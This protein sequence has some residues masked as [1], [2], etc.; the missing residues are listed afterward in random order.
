M[1]KLQL[2][3]LLPLLFAHVAL[4][5]NAIPPDPAA[6]AAA[7]RQLADS[8]KPVQGE[9]LLKG[10]AAKAV[11]PASLQYL[12]AKDTEVV[13]TKIWGNP[14]GSG[15]LGMV[16]PTGFDPLSDD[17]W[18][19]IMTLE[20][21]GYVKDDDAARIDYTKLLAEMKEG[22]VEANKARQKEGY[23]PIELVGWASPPRY[24]AAEK[25]LY[26]A[27]ELKFGNSPDHTLNYNLRLLGRRG[28]L[29]LNAVA[30]MSQLKDVEAATPAI[31]AAV[32]FQEGHRYADFNQSTDKTATYGVAAL[33]AG[34]V[35][36]KTG[37][38]KGLWIGILAFKKFAIIGI[39]ALVALIRKIWSSVRGRPTSAFTNTAGDGAP[40]VA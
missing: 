9:I 7:M 17:S 11:L 25:K 3:L 10:G 34:G 36:A 39:I 30:N 6:R 8:L 32:N 20:E 40:P 12:N 35:A 5:A 33:V 2:L 27:K 1:K 29:V 24:D 37:L 31:L 38:L 14:S 23:E 26:W 16:V 18:A 28:V 13:L 22:M 19:V 15:T 4:G 21:D